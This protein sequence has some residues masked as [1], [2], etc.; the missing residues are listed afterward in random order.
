MTNAVQKKISIVM[1]THEMGGKG[2]KY[3]DQQFA[4]ILQ[5]TTKDFDLV[6]SDQSTDNLIENRCEYY[7]DRVD[8]K[9]HRFDGP[10]RAANNFNNAMKLATSEILKPLFVDDRMFRADTLETYIRIHDEN[11]N[12]H[13]AFT[14][15]IHC[16]DDADGF[17]K[18]MKLINPQIPVWNPEIYLYN[19]T[20]CPS[21]MS[22]LNH[23]EMPTM[24]DTF[25]W[26]NDVEWYMRLY[27]KYDFP[28]L[29]DDIH[30]LIRIHEE[31]VTSHINDDTKQS[32]N[33]RVRQMYDG[34]TK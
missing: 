30:T 16:L 21:G 15:F 33:E 8:I 9:Y 22:I 12:H 26:V 7:S 5:Q 1:P 6:V 11:P 14:G 2:I 13:W 25:M 18:E 32:E 20:G 19:T 3:F 34:V 23:E 24:D 4:A 27:L 31:S 10:R 29:Y 28:V 17:D